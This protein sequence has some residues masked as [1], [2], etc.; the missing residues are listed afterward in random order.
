MADPAQRSRSVY[1]GNLPWDVK[2]EDLKGIFN[3]VGTII[4]LRMPLDQDQ[5]SKGFAFCEFREQDSVAMAIKHFNG[6]EFSGRKMKVDSA[7]NNVDKDSRMMGPVAIEQQY[8]EACDPVQAPEKIASVI[9][10]MAPAQVH[11]IISEA[12]R[13]LQGDPQEART[14]LIN[15]PQ[16]AYALLLALVR[17]RYITKER[18]TEALVKSEPPLLPLFP[19][20]RPPLLA[21]APP[22]HMPPPAHLAMPSMGQMPQQIHS[23]GTVGG[24]GAGGG[25]ISSGNVMSP[26]MYGGPPSAIPQSRGPPP[27]QRQYNEPVPQLHSRNQHYNEPGMGGGGSQSHIRSPVYQ[28]PQFP[29]G[30]PRHSQQERPPNRRYME[31]SVSGGGGVERPPARKFNE[32]HGGTPY[33]SRQF[34]EPTRSRATAD[35]SRGADRR[36]TDRPPVTRADYSDRSP[37]E[38][39]PVN[40]S[41]RTPPPPAPVTASRAE[42]EK[43]ELIMQ[44]LKLKEEDIAKMSADQQRTVRT[45]R[46]QFKSISK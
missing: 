5:K 29:Q 22:M 46:D 24:V 10:N 16:L 40:R 15:N 28:E 45:L 18:G 26:P 6:F 19:E 20:S 1:I 38:R 42:Q 17:G 34:N 35:N 39:S 14:A 8:G 3:K 30:P 27:P 23:I 43:A 33:E 2:E 21:H 37:V 44:V 13:C 11:D 9:G 25:I 31:T 7:T 32:P 41:P 4:S 36:P 12:R